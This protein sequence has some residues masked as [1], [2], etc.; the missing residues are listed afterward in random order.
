MEEVIEF[1]IDTADGVA[2]CRVEITDTENEKR[3]FVVIL[4]PHITNGMLMSKVYEH[5]LIPL[6]GGGYR[7]SDAAAIHPHVQLLEQDIS[8]EI[9]KNRK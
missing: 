3:T 8:A 6:S 7:F 9:L 4:Y 1:S 2:D 5:E